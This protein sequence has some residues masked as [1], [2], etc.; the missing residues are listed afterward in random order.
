ME[1]SHLKILQLMDVICPFAAVKSSLLAGSG[2]QLISSSLTAI[3]F[4]IY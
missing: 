4:D 3:E 2:E 1:G